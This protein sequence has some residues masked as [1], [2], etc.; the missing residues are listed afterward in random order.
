M[1]SPFKVDDIV[2]IDLSSQSKRYSKRLLGIVTNVFEE[3]PKVKGELAYGFPW[4]GPYPFIRVYIPSIVGPR[5]GD[6]G[7]YCKTID[8]INKGEVVLSTEK[9]KAPKSKF[10]VGDRVA[11]KVDSLNTRICEGTV[12]QVPTIKN[13]RTTIMWD[14]CDAENDRLDE[15]T[16]VLASEAK[17]ERARIKKLIAS[18]KG[19]VEDAIDRAIVALEQA[20]ECMKLDNSNLNVFLSGRENT[21]KRLQKALQETCSSACEREEDY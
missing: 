2:S 11:L 15:D 16:L 18:H 14:G 1:T 3:L 10:K 17:V 6:D 21:M 5:T 19:Y 8:Q 20:N 7:Y 9:L 13:A 4:N 12:K